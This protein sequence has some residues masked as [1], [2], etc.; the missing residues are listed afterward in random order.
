MRPAGP[1]AAKNG[2]LHVLTAFVLMGGW[3]VFANRA[4]PLPEALVAGALQGTMSGL[5]TLGLKRLVERVSQRFR[6]VAGLVVPP[7]TAFALS[8]TL[9]I[10]LHS[11]SGTPEIAR[12]IVVPL[13]V[14]TGYAA[15]YSWWLWKERERTT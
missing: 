10:L 12:T 3:A 11:A 15:L 9:L 13:T 1:T 8:A 2:L 14:S 7:L 5:I 6:G 4:H